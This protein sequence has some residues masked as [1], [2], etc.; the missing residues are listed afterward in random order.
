MNSDKLDIAYAPESALIRFLTL[1]EMEAVAK[2]FSRNTGLEYGADEDEREFV[3]SMWGFPPIPK[4][5]YRD[6]GDYVRNAPKSAS[7]AVIGHPAYML[8]DHLTKRRDD[9]TW[10]SWAIR[11]FYLI[12]A[13]GYWSEKAEYIDFLSVNDYDYDVNDI[14]AYHSQ[15]S[16]ETQI[17]L[18]GRIDEETFALP[19]EE[20]ERLYEAALYKCRYISYVE[21]AR[22]EN[23]LRDKFIAADK[24]LDGKESAFDTNIAYDDPEGFWMEGYGGRLEQFRVE[25]LKRAAHEAQI[26]D[27][28][29]RLREA[30]EDYTRPDNKYPVADLAPNMQALLKN[31][32][33]LIQT[34]NIIT[35]VINIPV[36]ISIPEGTSTAS[37]LVAIGT[38]MKAAIRQDNLRQVVFDDGERLYREA[39]ADGDIDALV[40]F[41]NEEYGKAWRRL[42]L[43]YVNYC[44][45]NDDGDLPYQNYSAMQVGLAKAE[46]FDATGID[47]GEL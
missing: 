43:A 47:L 17:D 5:M 24:I 34:M 7:N 21:I 40:D 1:P 3:V 13:A 10:Q 20:V 42:R 19:I 45:V 35:S 2:I 39:F 37:R 29:R 26:E 18:I 25:F 4:P 41:Y 28:L 6:V 38:Q 46:T 23:E 33:S 15:A 22:F 27:D 31:I 16:L 44:V 9:E 8:P 36:F 11:M 14:E 30:G 32:N 12:D